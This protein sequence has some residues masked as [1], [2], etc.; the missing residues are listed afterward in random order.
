[1]D[2]RSD[3]ALYLREFQTAPS[4]GHIE[5]SGPLH[6]GGDQSQQKAGGSVP[7]RSAGDQSPVEV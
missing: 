6:L 5:R 3:I 7:D 4:V 1:M 2:V